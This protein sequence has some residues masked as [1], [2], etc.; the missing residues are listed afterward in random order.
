[1]SKYWGGM[2]DANTLTRR[3]G[4]D[5]STGLDVS[6]FVKG[7]GDA[8]KTDLG[9]KSENKPSF[10]S[11]SAL[12]NNAFIEFLATTVLLY[13]VVYVPHFVN[14]PLAQLV[15]GAAIV[16]VMMTLKDRMYFCPDGSFMVTF[17]LLCAG[18]YTGPNKGGTWAERIASQLRAT[19]DQMP[20]VVIRI[21]GQLAA[22]Y[23]VYTV[24]VMQFRDELAGVPVH[25]LWDGAMHGNSTHPDLHIG[26]L[27]ANEFISTAIECIAA[28]FCIM[29]L[30]RPYKED[31][32]AINPN[33]SVT[34]ASKTDTQPPENKNL[35]NAAVCLG[36]MHIVL[37][38]LFRTTMNPFVFFMH[39]EI[40]GHECAFGDYYPVY[41]AQFGGLLTAGVYTYHYLPPPKALRSIFDSKKP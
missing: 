20:D 18:A 33:Y 6:A 37:E 35:F 25:Q 7:T 21:I 27:S 12:L 2:A 41:L 38:R 11:L 30:L 19:R 13:S 16:A 15:P 1:M 3:S 4:A 17:T 10:P 28:S 24:V 22:C 32:D 8:K 39:C 9:V 29:P 40:M 34:F 5:V 23:F 36:L 31:N 14:D 26:V